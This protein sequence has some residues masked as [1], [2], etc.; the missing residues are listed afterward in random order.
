MA[1]WAK[2]AHWKTTA[3]QKAG[4]SMI[5]SFYSNIFF[6]FFIT[7]GFNSTSATSVLC[8]SHSIPTSS[9]TF[10][11]AIHLDMTTF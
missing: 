9:F 1:L 10:D 11:G 4:N 8:F 7:S 2:K 3:Q 6:K 5:S